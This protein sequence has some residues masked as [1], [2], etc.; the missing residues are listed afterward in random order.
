MGCAPPTRIAFYPCGPIIVRE[1]QNE[2]CK[3]SG[4]KDLCNGLF[5]VHVG[6]DFV[7]NGRNYLYNTKLP[8]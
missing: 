3:F 5:P 2:K 7:N 8:F 4:M 6:F 1:K